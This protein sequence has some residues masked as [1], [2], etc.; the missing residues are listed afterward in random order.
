MILRRTTKKKA[1]TIGS[2]VALVV[3]AGSLAWFIRQAPLVDAAEP[4]DQNVYISP[5]Y[6]AMDKLKFV[7]NS[8]NNYTGPITVDSSSPTTQIISHVLRKEPAGWI[9]EV[10]A[11][12]YYNDAGDASYFALT[13][14]ICF[15]EN[16]G[17]TGSN[18]A[19]VM[20]TVSYTTASGTR[21]AYY[22]IHVNNMC[23]AYNSANPVVNT[24][25]TTNSTTGTRSNGKQFY[26]NYAIPQDFKDN[27]LPD[28]ATGGLYKLKISI[29]YDP[30]IAQGRDDGAGQQQA[31]FDIQLPECSYSGGC[32][33]YVA[34]V[35]AGSS[36]R[37]YSTIRMGTGNAQKFYTTQRFEFGLPCTDTASKSN[38]LVKFFDIDNSVDW[39]DDYL[40]NNNGLSNMKVGLYVEK[41][42]DGGNTWTRLT[43]PSGGVTSFTSNGDADWDNSAW[44]WG[45]QVLRG[46]SQKAKVDTLHITMDPHVRYRA[47][48]T[49]AHTMNLLGVGLPYDSIYG[50][51]G[52][53]TGVTGSIASDPTTP[54]SSGDNVK[55]TFSAHRDAS[56]P[57]IDSKYTYSTRLWFDTTGNSSFGAG[58]TLITTGTGTACNFSSGLIT[59]AYNGGAGATKALGDCLVSNINTNAAQICA[60]LTLV[61]QAGTI[62]GTPNPAVTCL[63]IAKSPALYVQNGDIR[64]GGAFPSPTCTLSDTMSSNGDPY[65]ILTHDY[66]SASRGS[67]GRYAGVA[68]G[69]IENYGAT[70][71]YFSTSFSTKQLLFATSNFNP[72]YGSD[73]F[74]WGDDITSTSGFCLPN[75][76]SIYSTAT[77]LPTAT[78]SDQQLDSI[79][80]ISKDT[81]G[82]TFT[83]S[84]KTLTIGHSDLI[85]P[86]RGVKLYV[87]QAAGV[88]GSKIVIADNIQYDDAGY[89]SVADLPQVIIIADGDIDIQI[90]PNVT[91]LDG[92][93][94]T[95]GDIYTCTGYSGS[96]NPAQKMTST[97]CNQQLTV[98]GALIAAGRVLPY[99]TFGYDTILDTSPAEIF[100]LSATTLLGDY[101][102]AG[103]LP[104][105]TTDKQTELPTRL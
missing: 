40:G 99:R 97:I 11:A 65:G 39:D 103:G 24:P 17:F 22:P 13:G 96:N 54:V 67:Y 5:N 50:L 68:R 32:R 88:T 34:P 23:T 27:A 26:A 87:S 8:N 58:D 6:R 14:G 21:S 7:T 19:F 94:S 81:R 48:I 60:S 28:P 57:T 82:Y 86:G 59:H 70:A 74:F 73:G 41:S 93:Y 77:I 37:N 16:A 63:Y 43:Y 61:G 71:P 51:I 105:I 83:A 35:A 98:N 56:F 4:G 104:V 75:V 30:D 80:L 47:V 76:K 10:D 38:Q 69:S 2:M 53:D 36:S 3:A 84:N 100:N 91:R 29:A 64:T 72:M 101:K 25:N 1:V 15:A 46:S 20:V 31:R 42:T 44:L 12:A 49:P 9:E 85:G 90:N 55:F 45:G 18:K 92:I 52:C 62:I 33:R 66:K 78:G 102:R 89:G 79:D 95:G